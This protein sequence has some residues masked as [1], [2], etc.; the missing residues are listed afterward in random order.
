[1]KWLRILT[2]LFMVAGVVLLIWAHFI[3]FSQNADGSTYGLHS[4]VEDIGMGVCALSVGLFLG[5]LF[6]RYKKWKRLDEIKA[7]SVLAL[8]I[9]AN[10]ADILLAIATVIYY[11]YRG[12][13]GDYPPDADSIG[14][15]IAM[16]SSG[17]LFFLLPMNVFLI[18]STLRSSTC[19]PGPMF[20]KTIKNT[21]S[22]VGWKIVL[23]A[24][25]L[26]VLVFLVLIVVDGDTLSTWSMQMFLYVLLSVR[27]GKVN[28]YNSKA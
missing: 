25:I 13:R 11:S 21:A 3:P 10:L 14:I 27:A 7:G 8:F 5:L 18:V 28:Y 24:L 26:L 17:I 20:Q 23:H 4:Q 1:M 9:M 22:L 6:F 16:Q 12:Y 15:P 19:L 2:L